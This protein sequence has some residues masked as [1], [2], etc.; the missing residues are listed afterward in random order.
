VTCDNKNAS[1]K[2]VS[3]IFGT[4]PESIKLAPVI[5]ALRKESD[6]FNCHICVTAQHRRMLDQVLRV[7]RIRPD[8][9]LNLME[10]G[11]SPAGFASRALLAI[12]DYL[13]REKPALVLIQGDTTT[14]VCS[15]LAAFYHQIPVAHVEAGL[16]T[17]NR[18]SPFPEEMNRRLASHLSTLH[19]APTELNKQNLLREGIPEETIHV[20]GNTVIDALFIA[21]ER[22]R[23]NPPA[24]PGLPDKDLSIFGDRKVVLITG[25]RR[26]NFGPGLESVCRAIAILAGD[27]PEVHFVYP[28]HL[29]PRVQAPVQRILG[30]PELKN[31]H[32]L[33]PLDYLP[34]VALMQRST[35][36]LTDSGGIQEEAP[37]LGVPVLVFRDHT[38]RPEGVGTGAVRLTGTDC[39]QIV[40][41]TSRLLTDEAACH[42]MAKVIHPYGDGHAAER[43]VGFLK[44][45]TVF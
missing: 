18:Y 30:L 13:T 15:S 26:E 17:G 45:T 41:E 11:Q 1:L 23:Q 7:F 14:V 20:T 40:K 19:F 6:H 43:I 33:P 2:K 9:D 3:V 21:L 29:N 16:R 8:A 25:H 22:I 32:L 42:D 37:A 5:L 34:F 35:L 39:Q 27:F 10:H 28:V 36:I 44:T 24:V 12:D 38:E 31:I 4:R